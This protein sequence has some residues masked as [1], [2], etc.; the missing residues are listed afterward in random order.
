M[1]HGFRGYGLYA[2]GSSIKEQAAS[3]LRDGPVGYGK[4]GSVLA[5]VP[6]LKPLV[7]DYHGITSREV[8][9]LQ[10][11]RHEIVKPAAA[12][13]VCIAFKR[14]AFLIMEIPERSVFRH[15]LQKPAVD[16][17]CGFADGILEFVHLPIKVCEP[18]R[19]GAGRVAYAVA[20]R[21]AIIVDA[22]DPERRPEDVYLDFPFRV[23][24]AMMV[25]RQKALLR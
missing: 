7:A 5:E 21:H 1:P 4:S 25:N 19:G 6:A 24:E 12:L 10:F 9:T 17:R 16:V 22:A 11:L 23:L 20:V 18:D 3:D 2:W 14:H 8:G 15:A 13:V